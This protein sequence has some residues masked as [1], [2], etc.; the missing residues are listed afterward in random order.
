MQQEETQ[1]IAIRT[2]HSQSRK[3]EGITMITFAE[4]L[5]QERIDAK[6]M[7]WIDTLQSWAIY[8]YSLRNFDENGI[9]QHVQISKN[10]TLLNLKFAPNDITK[11][12]KHP[13]E[14]NFK[15]LKSRIE[16][17]QNNGVDATRWVVQRHF[18]VAFAFTN[19][20]VVLFGIPLVVMKPKSGMGF[21]VG[22]SFLVMFSYYAFIKFGQS[23]GINGV[24]DP[25][26][27]AWL[28]NIVFISG[29]LLLLFSV[30]K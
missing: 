26:L 12:I 18:K 2:Y 14:L 24:M 4:N 15:E 7:T 20:I 9:E 28:G 23:L 11:G 6:R 19:L 25:M 22:T 1:H 30:R 21:S 16:Y 29:G 10:D 27:S 8:D 3:A 13:E 17:L 5:I